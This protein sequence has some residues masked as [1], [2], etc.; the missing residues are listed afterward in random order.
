MYRYLVFALNIFLH[1]SRVRLNISCFSSQF[2]FYRILLLWEKTYH[3]LPK[4]KNI[5]VFNFQRFIW[6]WYWRFVVTF[7]TFLFFFALLFQVPDDFILDVYLLLEIMLYCQA[8]NKLY[9]FCSGVSKKTNH[10]P[11]KFLIFLRNLPIF[12]NHQVN[13]HSEHITT[14]LKHHYYVYELQTTFRDILGCRK[15][16]YV[17]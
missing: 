12:Y 16:W 13:N 17:V 7:I 14:S 4:S 15:Y 11:P 8:N 5:F 6:S 2:F 3:L 1:Y 9:K 10:V